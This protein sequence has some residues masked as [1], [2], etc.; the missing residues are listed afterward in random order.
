MISGV[1]RRFLDVRRERRSGLAQFEAKVVEV[2][3][4]RRMRAEFVN[5]GSE[6]VEGHVT[7]PE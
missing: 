3:F 7:L 2:A 5:G 1:F 6:A 4:W